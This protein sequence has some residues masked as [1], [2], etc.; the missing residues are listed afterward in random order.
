MTMRS[1]E[2]GLGG[3]QLAEGLVESTLE[4]GGVSK[5]EVVEGGDTWAPELTMGVGWGCVG[6]A[7]TNN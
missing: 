2:G 3:W 4:V 7:K 1:W 6:R 5:L